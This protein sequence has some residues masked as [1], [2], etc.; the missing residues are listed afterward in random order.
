MAYLLS[1]R[2]DA[3]R[4]TVKVAYPFPFALR[5]LSRTARLR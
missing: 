2:E 4:Y 3:R 5:P 1:A